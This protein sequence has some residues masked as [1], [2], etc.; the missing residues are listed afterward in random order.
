MHFPS[1][2]S[3][4]GQQLVAIPHILRTLPLKTV[5]V[6]LLTPCFSLLE[7]LQFLYLG[8]KH[9]SLSQCNPSSSSFFF[10][11]LIILSPDLAKWVKHVSTS[12]PLCQHENGGAHVPGLRQGEGRDCG[13]PHASGLLPLHSVLSVSPHNPRRELNF[14]FTHWETEIQRNEVIS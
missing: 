7:K 14:K 6:S 10:F 2:L 8:I 4:A 13:V 12:L 9:L 11:Q 1:V 3:G 5:I